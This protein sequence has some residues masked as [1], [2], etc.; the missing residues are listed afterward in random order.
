MRD[1]LSALLVQKGCEGV[2]S[3]SGIL[4]TKWVTRWLR[5]D[6]KR[7]FPKPPQTEKQ[8]TSKNKCLHILELRLAK[9]NPTGTKNPC[10]RSSQNARVDELL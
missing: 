6:S 1:P 4:S 9:E 5:A 2:C 8:Q 7:L 10:F 3:E